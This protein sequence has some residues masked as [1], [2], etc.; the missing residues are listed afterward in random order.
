MMSVDWSEMDETSK[1]LNEKVVASLAADGESVQPSKP[2]ASG[3]KGETRQTDGE[4]V[5]PSKEDGGELV[6]A[7]ARGS[8][9]T[10]GDSGEPSREAARPRRRLTLAEQI[11]HKRELAEKQRAAMERDRAKLESTEKRLAEL[12][13]M[14][15]AKARKERDHRLI[16]SAA[17]FESY[18]NRSLA[19]VGEGEELAIADYTVSLDKDTAVE[20]AKLYLDAHPELA[21]RGGVR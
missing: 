18:V 9:P 12:E 15:T 13:K 14:A 21:H 5:Q 20:C 8:T 16:E 2:T 19:G 11:A 17:T 4:S 7:D 10:D 1:A 3:N 6:S